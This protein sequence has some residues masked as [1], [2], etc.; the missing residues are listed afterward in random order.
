MFVLSKMMAAFGRVL[1]ELGRADVELAG[2]AF[3]YDFLPAADQFFPPEVGLVDDGPDGEHRSRG[4][5]RIA[6]ERRARIA[7]CT[8]CFG[9]TMTD[10]DT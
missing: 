4:L 8:P 3:A 9:P 10:A 5:P 1:R 2:S 7:S 6:G